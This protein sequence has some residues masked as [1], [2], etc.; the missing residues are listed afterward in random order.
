MAPH[1][2]GPTR[3]TICGS[4]KSAYAIAAETYDENLPTRCYD[5]GGI[6]QVSD[7]VMLGQT[8]RIAFNQ[9]TQAWKR[10]DVVAFRP[11]KITRPS[12]PPHIKRI[13][14]LPGESLRIQDG[15]AWINGRLLQKNMA[16]LRRLA[17]PVTRLSAHGQGNWQITYEPKVDSQNAGPSAAVNLDSEIPIIETPITL[18]SGQSLCWR[19][20]VPAPV[21]PDTSES[22]S[23][24]KPGRLTDDL[25]GNQGLSYKLHAV[26]DRLAEIQLAHELNARLLVTTAYRGRCIAI[27]VEPSD[28]SHASKDRRLPDAEAPATIRITCRKR[29]WLACCDDQVLLQSDTES[30]QLDHAALKA[31]MPPAD[32]AQSTLSMQCFGGSIEF[33]EVAIARDVYLRTNGRTGGGAQEFTVPRD[34]YLVLGDNPAASQDSRGDLGFVTSTKILGKVVTAD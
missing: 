3:Q 5:C 13:W 33:Q 10:F 6:C 19:H 23:W 14:G 12:G 9:D 4:C 11:G 17:I 16:E 28:A 8:V 7:L 29:L 34:G 26:E 15:E 1:F 25:P 31:S 2:K 22:I 20:R 27:S 18:E 21:H 24:M 32:D 30:I